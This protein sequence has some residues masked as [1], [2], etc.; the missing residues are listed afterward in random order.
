MMSHTALLL[1]SLL[2]VAEAQVPPPPPAPCEGSVP[3]PGC[4]VPGSSD[5]VLYYLGCIN[6][7]FLCCNFAGENNIATAARGTGPG[8]GGEHDF[9]SNGE[10]RVSTGGDTPASCYEKCMT[11]GLPHVW[12]NEVSGPPTPYFALDWNVE[13]AAGRCICMEEPV[14]CLLTNPAERAPLSCGGHPPTNVIAAA[15]GLPNWFFGGAWRKSAFGPAPSRYLCDGAPFQPMGTHLPDVPGPGSCAFGGTYPEAS[16][17]WPDLTAPTED[18]NPWTPNDDCAGDWA[19]TVACEAGADRVWVE[20]TAQS[21]TGAACPTAP[22][23]DAADCAYGDGACFPGCT[24]ENAGN[25]DAAATRDDGSCL[26]DGF[27]MMQH[28]RAVCST[29]NGDMDGNEIVDVY[30]IL[31]LLGD[32]GLCDPRLISDGTNDGCVGTQDLLLLLEEF[33]TDCT[34]I[35]LRGRDAEDATTR[36]PWVELAPDVEGDAEINSAWWS[37]HCDAGPNVP[38]NDFVILVKMGEVRDYFTV[39]PRRYARQL[40]VSWNLL[41]TPTMVCLFA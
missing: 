28:G 29:C 3:Q 36:G 9:G 1:A 19:C 27:R 8:E 23:P 22:P 7:Y 35:C 41:S 34:D 10:I 32:F 31:A 20:T 17:V 18:C 14:A 39:R 5:P 15:T 12:T 4:I 30:D 24:D 11:G 21:G 2:V 40:R 26:C 6:D 16:G 13:T 25:Y 37:S 33:G 38:S